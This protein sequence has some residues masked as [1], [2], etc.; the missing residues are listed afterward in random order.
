MEQRCKFNRCERE[1]GFKQISNTALQM[2]RS[3]PKLTRYRHE[4]KTLRKGIFFLCYRL[5][6][7]FF[8]V[9]RSLICN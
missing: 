6:R 2:P 7:N 9:I 5:S 1:Y 4:Y 3:I 8:V